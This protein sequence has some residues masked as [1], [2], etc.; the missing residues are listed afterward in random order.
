MPS[1][2]LCYAPSHRSW[3][4]TSSS[5]APFS[6]SWD[7]PPYPSSGGTPD[8]VSSAS[9]YFDPFNDHLNYY[10][11]QHD[12]RGR[13]GRGGR[14]DRDDYDDSS[15]CHRS[16]TTTTTMNEWQ[17][18]CGQLELTVARLMRQVEQLRK[19]R[20]DLLLETV[21]TGTANLVFGG[22]TGGEREQYRQQVDDRLPPPPA[23]PPVPC[24][25]DG[26]SWV[27][28]AQTTSSK[29]QIDPT[30]SMSKQNPPPCNAFYLLGELPFLSL[31]T[32]C[33]FKVL[34]ISL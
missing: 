13:R 29:P 16:N 19:E 23:A 12:D 18:K 27:P 2:G 8:S 17:W 33:E 9:S 26:K 21:A 1:S 11:V 28:V 31:S 25:W 14:D 24:R 30:K 3:S 20:D 22:V 10:S 6:T 32:L 34:T 5:Q 15:R 4:S 7:D